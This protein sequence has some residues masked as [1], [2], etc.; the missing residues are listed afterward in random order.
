[1][2]AARI[3]EMPVA[4]D[5]ACERTARKLVAAAIESDAEEIEEIT[6]NT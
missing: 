5:A 6:K 4:D 2:K 3:L 1:M